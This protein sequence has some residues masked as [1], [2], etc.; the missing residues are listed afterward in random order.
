MNW[1]AENNIGNYTLDDFTQNCYDDSFYYGDEG[2]LALSASTLKK[3]LKGDCPKEDN[4]NAHALVFGRA[5]HEAVLEPEKYLRTCKS[6]VLSADDK[7][8]IEVLKDSL[9]HSFEFHVMDEINAVEVPYVGFHNDVALKCKVDA[10]CDKYMVDIK[11][12]SNIDIT[13]F[14][15]KHFGYHIS[16]YQYWMLTGKLMYFLYVE[17]QTGRVKLVIPDKKFYEDGRRDWIWAMRNYKLSLTKQWTYMGSTDLGE[18]RHIVDKQH[19]KVENGSLYVWMRKPEHQ[20][21]V[22]NR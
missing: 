14:T 9:E 8:H 7:L 16:A 13:Q 17:K 12:T 11:T 18:G 2:K 19:I 4:P 10:E 20:R 22:F 21:K 5:F 6:D 3:Y 1:G 15:S